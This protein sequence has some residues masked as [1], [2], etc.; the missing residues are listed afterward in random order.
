MFFARFMELL[1]VEID[2]RFTGRKLREKVA[3]VF[4][5]QTQFEDI[6]GVGF[7]V[8]KDV[9]DPDNRLT[10]LT[11]GSKEDYIPLQAADLI[12]F[13]ARRILTH[14]LQGKA[15][16]DPFERKLE[17]RHNLMLHYFTRGQLFDFARIGVAAKR[18]RLKNHEAKATH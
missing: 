16:R 10:S 1:T 4:E 9:I 15:W 8:I 7:H 13:Y 12:A 11:F 18:A 5:Q 14:Q 3:F 6:A 17:E 2:K